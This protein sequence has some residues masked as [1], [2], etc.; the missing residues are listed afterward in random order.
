MERATSQPGPVG[1]AGR[2]AAAG[3]AAVELA[4]SASAFFFS[5]SA[6]LAWL[7]S[8]KPFGFCVFPQPQAGLAWLPSDWLL[9]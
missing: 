2:V 1:A 8:Q 6:Y 5:L 9:G 3:L 7:P 4:E